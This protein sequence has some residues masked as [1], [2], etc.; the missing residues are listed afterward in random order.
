MKTD[1]TIRLFN[2]HI[3]LDTE[4]MDCVRDLIDFIEVIATNPAEDT[5]V[6][7]HGELI[8]I[9]TNRSHL[10]AILDCLTKDYNIRLK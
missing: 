10:Y 4:K 1:L 9:Y 2:D 8:M 3:T 6:Y 7:R 5:T